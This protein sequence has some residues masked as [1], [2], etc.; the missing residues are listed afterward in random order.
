M[1]QQGLEEQQLLQL[2]LGVLSDKPEAL[3]KENM[4]QTGED[5]IT[6][7]KKRRIMM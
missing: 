5:E 2:T 3:I 4:E 1:Q 7:V 6:V